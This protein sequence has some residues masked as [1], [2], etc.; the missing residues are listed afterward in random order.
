MDA[1]LLDALAEIL[2]EALLA[3]IEG[4]EEQALAIA[5]AGSPTGSGS[6]TQDLSASSTRT[7][8]S[9]ASKFQPRP[10]AAAS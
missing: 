5:A 2:A 6:Q 1:Q 7:P 8:S 3:D 9:Y 10:V 4:E